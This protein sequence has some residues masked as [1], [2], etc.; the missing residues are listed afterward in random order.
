[1]SKSI[2]I[3]I[4]LIS[5]LIL[6]AAVAKFRQIPAPIINTTNEN[7]IAPNSELIIQGSGFIEDFSAANKTIIK[8]RN[9]KKKIELKTIASSKDT[10]T[11]LVPDST[12]LGDYDLFIYL[13]T[14]FFKSKIQRLKDFVKIRPKAPEKPK[15]KFQIIKNQSEL[16]ELI[17]QNQGQELILNL[18]Q[19]LKLG[20]NIVRCFYYEEGFKS[21]MSEAVEI[22][23]L[24]QNEVKPK[25]AIHSE[26]PLESYAET[27]DLNQFD[28]TPITQKAESGLRRTYH[29]QTP[30]DNFY[31][32]TEIT[33]SPLYIKEAHVKTPEYL[34]IK[35][36]DSNTYDLSNCRIEDAVA[37]RYSFVPQ[38]Q[39]EAQSERKIEGNL[40]LNDT[41]DSIK[42]ICNEEIIEEIEYTKT[43]ADGFAIY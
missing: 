31:L 41:G 29:L 3:S 4:L 43:T 11:V 27:M 37:K 21:L 2:K 28:V 42:I 24:N 20:K 23:Y 18:E 19:E 25:L 13:K 16:L 1:M 36:R 10:I 15:L 26:R 39:L 9:S 12:E 8:K 17:D 38:E 40:S 22:Y 30:S 32:A 34:V 5:S 14:K 7:L 35:N 33:L 6:S